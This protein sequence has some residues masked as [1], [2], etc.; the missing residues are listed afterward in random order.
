MGRDLKIAIVKPCQN[1]IVV[2][3]VLVRFIGDEQSLKL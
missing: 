1:D 3:S 2:H